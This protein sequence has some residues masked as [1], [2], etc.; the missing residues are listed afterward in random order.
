MAKVLFFGVC[1]DSN[2]PAKAGR[3]RAVL[4]E[5]YKGAQVPT[6]YDANTLKDLLTQEKY[7][8]YTTV[9]ELKWSKD[10]PHLC[11]PFLP[12]FINVVPKESENVNILFYDPD[13]DTQNKM[14]VGP[15]ISS[16]ENLSYEKYTTGRLHTSKGTRVEG[17]LN[18]TDSDISN[19]TFAEPTKISIEGRSNS[20]MVFSGTEGKDGEITMRA[21]KFIPN[22]PQPAFPIFNPKPSTLQL[23]NFPTKLSLQEEPKVFES[24]VEAPIRYLVEYDV[25]NLDTPESLNGNVKLYELKV[26]K[27]F[28]LPTNLDSPGLTTNF[29]TQSDL[30]VRAELNFTNQAVSGVTYLIN[31]FLEEVGTFNDKILTDPPFNEGVLSGLTSGAFEKRGE[32]IDSF[33]SMA[34]APNDQNLNLFPFYFRPTI[35]FTEIVNSEDNSLSTDIETANTVIKNIGI[36]GVNNKKY[37]G[38]VLSKEQPEPTFTK[39]ETVEIN[40]DF[41]TSTRQGFIT[42]LS[43]KIILYSYDSAIPNKST[44]NPII[45]NENNNEVGDNLGLSQETLIKVNDSETEPTVRGDQLTMLLVK[46]VEFLRT[47]VHGEANTP[48]VTDGVQLLTEIDDLM[49]QG[50]Y[51]NKNIRI[52]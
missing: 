24:P 14:Y 29:Q 20:D 6:D 12:Y 40:R 43:D 46:I 25:F 10:D 8:M 41:D 49:R 28:N 50:N 37:Y 19:N 2:D 36:T 22:I 17:T 9:E 45:E 32:Y 7:S 34:P 51:L 27:P 39:H 44:T 48:A 30:K 1:V 42:A 35:S 38:F 18:I 47:H 13:N 5:D 3:I 11:S 4:D 23:S 21:G 33:S 52:N 15:T 26:K 31:E 16:P